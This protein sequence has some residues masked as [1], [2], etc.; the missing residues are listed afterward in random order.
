MK[1]ENCKLKIVLLAILMS[2]FAFALSASGQGAIS[3]TLSISPGLVRQTVKP[4]E[5]TVVKVK[6]SNL[7]TDPIPLSASKFSISGINN[8]GAPEFTAETRPHS[9]VDWLQADRPDLIL[10]ANGSQE[11]SV[12][13]MAPIG[14]IP[15]GYSA[16]MIFQARLPA[17]YFDPTANTKIIPSLSTSF[18]ISVDGG[19]PPSIDSLSISSFQMPKIIVS[20]PIPFIAEISNPTGFFFFTDGKLTLTPTWGEQK[21]VTQLAGSVLMPQSSRQ[22][23]T[24]YSGEIWPGIYNAEFSLNQDGKVLIAS[25]RFISIPWPFLILITCLLL[26]VGGLTIRYRRRRK[27]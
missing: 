12:S 9:A 1:I 24:A 21:T 19:T 13:I 4:G 3:P 23:T 10:D 11:V 25:S 27:I 5:K 20:A 16:I 2:V 17:N 26:V 15:G 6:V 7:G 14:T 8:Q 22:Y 18:L